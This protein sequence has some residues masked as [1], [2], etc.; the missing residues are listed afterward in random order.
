MLRMRRTTLLASAAVSLALVAA[1]CGGNSTS[2]PATTTGGAAPTTAAANNPNGTFTL[3]VDQ[4]PQNWNVLS[5]AG[6]EFAL[7][8]IVDRVL[9]S[10]FHAYPDY[11]IKLDTGFMV[12]AEQTSDS[13]QTIVYKINPK[14]VWSD[15]TPITYKDFQYAFQSQSGLPQ[16]KDSDGKAF[17]SATNSGYSQIKSVDMM[18]ND[19][20]T[21]Q[22]VFSTPYPDWKGLFTTMLQASKAST[23]GF[24]TGFTDP[25]KQVTSGGP[26]MIQS[27]N[28]GTSLTVVRNPM[29]WGTPA[30]LASV[31][32]RF[33]TNSTQIVP[34][35][36]NSEINGGVLTPQLDLVTQVKQIPNLTYSQKDGLEFEHLDFNQTNVW[37]KDPAI[38]QA[39]MLAV[40]RNQ[41]IAKTVGQFDTTVKPLNDRIFVTGQPGNQDNSGGGYSAADPAKAMSVLTAAGYTMTNGA[42][43]KGGKPVTLRISSTQGNALRA[44]EEQFVVNAL[45]PI[46]IKVTETDVASLG[47]TLAAGN[48]DL[49]IF[50]W[51]ATPFPSANDAIYQTANMTT[52]NGSSNYDAYSSTAADDIIT[53]VDATSDTTQRTS[54]YNQLDSQLWK[55]FYNLPLF[56]RAQGLAYSNKYSG[57]MNNPQQEGSTYNMEAWAQ[58]AA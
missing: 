33:V 40:D 6:N 17:N 16:Y 50:A 21:V 32:F 46:G 26:F 27:Y 1:A 35:L 43:M 10:V 28:A 22:T 34:A 5:S 53:K 45:A 54:M 38:R 42:L 18:N 39:I 14:A 56:Q 11:S 29:Y 4:E 31:V 58:K 47:K 52:G 7:Q 9:P 19:P 23:V 2:S 36:Q 8:T 20:Y 13:P 3:S 48:F 49:I 15:G 44:S 55:D 41:L 24:N 25:V 37:L 12:S 51:V 30:K 57:L